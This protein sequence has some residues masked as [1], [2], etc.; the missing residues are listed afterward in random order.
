MAPASV[1]RSEP[2]PPILGINRQNLSLML[3]A[4]LMYWL[5]CELSIQI[6]ASHPPYP[7]WLSE[8]FALGLWLIAPRSS[9]WLQLLAVF[10]ANMASTVQA[11]MPSLANAVA[12]SAVNVVQLA[13]SGWALENARRHF[14]RSG[15][16]LQLFMAL[17]VGP[18]VLINAVCA[19]AS[20][21]VFYYRT[22]VDVAGAFATIL[23]SDGLGV[24]LVTPLIVS[25]AD[26]IGRAELVES[27]RLKAE[28]A[29]VLGLIVAVSI[30][31][32]SLRPDPFGLVP[33]VFY[34]GIPFVLWAAI[35]FG[36]RGATLALTLHAL[37]A[38][39]FTLRDLGP[40][41]AGFIPTSQSVLQLQ[42][43]LAV[44]IVTTL[45]ASVLMR[46]RRT[47]AINALSWRMRYEAAL[48]ASGSVVYEIRSGSQRVVWAGDTLSALGIPPEA[49]STTSAWTA[50]IHPDDRARL[51]GLRRKLL[52]GE[53]SNIELT[54]R[55]R[56]DA[57]TFITVGVTAYSVA[58]PEVNLDLEEEEGRRI[59]GFVKDITEKVQE[60]EERKRL[61]A[62]LRHAQ[63][64][65][66]IGQLAGGIAHDFNNI[67]ASII[68][69]GELAKSRASGDE[70][71]QRHLDTILRAGERGRILVSQVLTFSRKMPEQRIPLDLRDVIDEVVLL[72]RGSNPHEILLSMGAGQHMT[73]GNPTELHQLFMNVVT[74]G[75]QAMPEGGVL[76]ISL[77]QLD[78]SLPI[79]VMHGRLDPGRYWKVRIQD[80][81]K[82]I[83][84]DTRRRMFEPFFTTKVVG[85]GTGLGL[86]LALS[87][88]KSHGGGIA[89]ESEPGQKTTFTIYLPAT[90]DTG[91]KTP[92]ALP[93]GHDER[94]LLVDDETPLRELAE[95]LLVEL[96]YQVASFGSSIEALAAFERHPAAFD[97]ILSDEVMPGMGGTQFASKVRDIRPDL[98]ILIITAYGGP[99]FE[100]RAQQAGVI[101]VLKKP[102]QKNE[103]ANALAGVFVRPRG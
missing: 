51:V 26:R 41:S 47:S 11:G 94:I 76:D 62:E 82:G 90:A 101:Q 27:L 16:T 8:G 45:L 79:D 77:E 10:V 78:A 80:E 72:A 39:H 100:L 56:R 17:L 74:N 34:L 50:H 83:D 67:L 98:P 33:P 2:S 60:Q 4:C 71:L 12:G 48:Q 43:Y 89:V 30:G 88:A 42:G 57:D 32:F 96:G 99:G 7:V 61:E 63:K 14:R 55:L 53:L 3:A 9:R 38:F 85:Q 64:M 75:V 97:A 37:I 92:V 73:E 13:A 66:A 103:L 5:L 81:G 21:L 31:V 70:A 15:N 95:E 59:I 54:A 87:I 18:V 91:G 40:F 49:I 69:Y 86:S 25:W 28:A 29:V 58:P 65:E 6:A 1:Q 19:Y 23:I 93:R 52:S 24:M 46:E 20:A 84:A 102:Y 36:L 44:L 22:G 35:R 68:G